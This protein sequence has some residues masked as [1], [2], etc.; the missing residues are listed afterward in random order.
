VNNG[1]RKFEYEP[2]AASKLLYEVSFKQHSS[3]C[4]ICDV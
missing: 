1:C 2:V 4:Q 3:V